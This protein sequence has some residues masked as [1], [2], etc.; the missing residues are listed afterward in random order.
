MHHIRVLMWPSQLCG[1][2]PVDAEDSALSR[3]GTPHNLVLADW[4]R[5]GM[6]GVRDTGDDQRG[7]GS[8]SPDPSQFVGQ[9]RSRCPSQQQHRGRRTRAWWASAGP[10]DPMAYVVFGQCPIRRNRRLLR[11]TPHNW[12]GH[13]RT[14]HRDRGEPHG[15]SPPTPPGIR[16]RTTAVRP[17]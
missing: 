8:R 3:F 7:R 15:S 6:A 1:L 12:L 5:P 11:P 4:N 13:I 16:V 17:D 14:V 2:Q 9:P 10:R